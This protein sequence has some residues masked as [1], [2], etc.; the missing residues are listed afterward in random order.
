MGSHAWSRGAIVG[1]RAT[2]QEQ[3]RKVIVE[4]AGGKRIHFCS[5]QSLTAH[6]SGGEHPMDFTDHTLDG[7]QVA[8][9]NWTTLSAHFRTMGLLCYLAERASLTGYEP[10]A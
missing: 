9:D 3:G 10:N 2:H 5:W 1:L 4:D 6:C 8:V 7:N